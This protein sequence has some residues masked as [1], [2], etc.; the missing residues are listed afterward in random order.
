MSS[1]FSNLFS[2]ARSK[3]HVS[4]G[5]K[6]NVS[7][8]RWVLL[9]NSIVRSSHSAAEAPVETD[10]PHHDLDPDS[11]SEQDEV[12][13]EQ[14][15]FMFPD[16]GK[17]TEES[18]S[19]VDHSEAQWFNSLWESLGDD[20]EDD[21]SSSGVQ[22]SV[23]PADDD[24]DAISPLPSPM[25]SSDDLTNPTYFATSMTYSYPYPVPYPPY[26]PPL[27]SPYHFDSTVDSSLSA[28]YDEPLPYY[29]LDDVEDLPVP[30]AIEDTSDDE[31]D[32]PTTPS[33]DQS[34]SLTLDPAS[35]PLPTG[36]S[37]LRHTDPHV[38]S[39]ADDSF[40]KPFEFDALPFSHV[41]PSY[42]LQEC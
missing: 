8:H 36:R 21:F 22:V 9:K 39:D 35:I 6:D 1:D 29:D 24:D 28:G 18:R 25:S 11:D 10:S 37:R 4:V 20:D 38:Y 2:L 32:A 30:D 17:C 16:V 34:T 33:L 41:L 3:L 23:L 5:S 12:M 26:H 42:F 40:F 19:S 15:S 31:S 7:L 27:I 14:D 13:V